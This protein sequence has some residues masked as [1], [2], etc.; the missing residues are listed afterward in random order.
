MKVIILGDLHFGARND[1]ANFH[2]YYRK[3]Y[4]NVLFPFMEK[5]GINVII[6]LGDI[7][8]R[9]KYVNFN[10]LHQ[11]KEYFFDPLME[12]GIKLYM[13]V[14]NHDCAFKNTNDVNSPRLLLS[15]YPNITVFD[16]DC[17][18]IEFDGTRFILV[19]WMNEENQSKILTQMER[20]NA[21]VCCG[22]FEISGFAMYEGMEAEHGLMS[23][24][25]NPF[26]LTLSGHYHHRSSKGNITYVGTPYELTWQDWGDTKGFHVLD[27][28]SLNMEFIENP[29]RMF[30]KITYNNGAPAYDVDHKYVKVVVERKDDQYAY[31]N[32]INRL[33]NSNLYDLK[34]I[35]GYTDASSLD[36]DDAISLEDTMAIVNRYVSAFSKNNAN[37]GV[38]ED[39]LQ[40]LMR[41]LY[42]EAMTYTGE[43]D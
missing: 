11:A 37:M 42:V 10:S 7:F 24:I 43:Q 39:E 14:G 35:E 16:D 34:V 36:E 12:K 13:P 38:D 6:Q 8:D 3:F 40:K 33:L 30:E 15:A 1:S 29:Y 23:D 17:G 19:P 32:F 2:D 31:D 25:F 41:Q 4:Q 21:R 27:T 20:S 9:R 28:G 5:E 22:H 18:D 26:D